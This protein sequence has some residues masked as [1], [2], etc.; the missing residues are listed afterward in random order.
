MNDSRTSAAAVLEYPWRQRP[1]P[2]ELTEIAD[3]VYWL[4]MPLPLGLDH[5]NLWLLRDEGG[6]MIVDTGLATDEIRTIWDSILATCRR[7]MPFTR[8]LVTHYHPDHL[9]LAGWLTEKLGVDVFMSLGDYLTAHAVHNAV[10]GYGPAALPDLYHRHGLGGARLEQIAARGNSYRRAVPVLPRRYRRIVDNESL[11]IGKRRW[12][13]IMGQ[14]HAPEHASLHCPDLGLLIAGDMALPR[15]S[16]NVSVN[17]AEP[18]GDPLRLFLESQLRFLD[19]PANTLVLPSHGK[20]YRG[21]HPRVDELCRHHEADMA[22]AADA[23]ATPQS[24]ADLLPVLFRRDLEGFHLS[25][26]MGEAIAHL[27]CLMHRGVLARRRDEDGVFRF[28][29]VA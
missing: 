23:C 13:V 28:L 21:L 5:I 20:P 22:R 11:L 1:A 6:W 3:G 4:S 24:A 17:S 27:N 19:L 29:R 26:A 14:G 2:A 7:D 18:D 16:A 8:I 10:G 12:R 9:G 25:L 15:I